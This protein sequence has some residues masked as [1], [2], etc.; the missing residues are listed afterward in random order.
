MGAAEVLLS[1]LR[2]ENMGDATTNGAGPA[3]V[4]TSPKELPP[5]D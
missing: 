3:P 2:N 5:K 1:A 4:A